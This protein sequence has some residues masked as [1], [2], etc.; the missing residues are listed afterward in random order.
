MIPVHQTLTETG[1]G[2]C[3][4]ASLASV[5]ELSLDEVP[6]FVKEHGL[7]YYHAVNEWLSQFG[8]MWLRV[9][10]PPDSL[11]RF[12]PLP[13]GAICLVTGHSP[14][15]QGNHSIVATIEDGWNVKL[16]HDPHPSGRGIVGKPWFIEFLVPMDPK[17]VKGK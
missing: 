15:G 17:V 16:L 9:V 7:N 13:A 4:S 12:R 8:L 11:P 5:L 3:L 14:R 2:N 10:V 1:E 6:D